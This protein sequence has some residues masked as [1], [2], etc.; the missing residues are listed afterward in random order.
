MY[1]ICRITSDTRHLTDDCIGTACG[2]DCRPGHGTG[3]ISPMRIDPSAAFYRRIVIDEPN[4]CPEC[5]KALG[6]P[7][8]TPAAPFV[9]AEHVEYLAKILCRAE[10]KNPNVIVAA[11]DNPDRRLGGGDIFMGEQHEQWKEY[12][13]I[14][15]RFI[16]MFRAIQGML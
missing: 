12:Q 1:F 16:T 10:G 9:S 14:A 8:P 13:Q 15:R 2:I 4:V 5:L 7:K 6:L 3:F 11:F